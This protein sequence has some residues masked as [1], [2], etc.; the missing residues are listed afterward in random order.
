MPSTA[1]ELAALSRSNAVRRAGSSSHGLLFCNEDF[2][3]RLSPSDDEIGETR[4][5]VG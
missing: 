2:M 5:Y 1:E 3:P 4:T